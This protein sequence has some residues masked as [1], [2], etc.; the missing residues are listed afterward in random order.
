M[1][2]AILH[3]VVAVV[4]S[5]IC[6]HYTSQGSR[7]QMHMYSQRF[8]FSIFQ[9]FSVVSDSWPARRC[10]E[11][12]NAVGIRPAECG[13]LDQIKQIQQRVSNAACP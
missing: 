1:L 2:I 13:A 6:V 3:V 7:G 9:Y 11:E 12:S 8:E 4:T 10:E 5:K